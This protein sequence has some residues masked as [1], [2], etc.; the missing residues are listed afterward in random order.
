MSVCPEFCIDMY[1]GLKKGLQ[2]SFYESFIR[3]VYKA[4]LI[5][6]VHT[7]D[8]EVLF[9]PFGVESNSKPLIKEHGKKFLK[10]Y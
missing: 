6:P 7:T 3:L 5:A 10:Q 1:V 9:S 4:L 8:F 2:P